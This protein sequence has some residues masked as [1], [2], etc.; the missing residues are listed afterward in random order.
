M[1]LVEF[2]AADTHL[3][4]TLFAYTPFSILEKH[5]GL[6]SPSLMLCYSHCAPVAVLSE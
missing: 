1:K 4:M 5:P 6:P 2:E 3:D